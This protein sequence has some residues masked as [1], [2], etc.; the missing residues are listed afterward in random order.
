[1][2]HELHES[3][4]T[5][6]RDMF[7]RNI[8]SW[9]SLEVDSQILPYQLSTPD[10]ERIFFAKSGFIC[11]LSEFLANF[12]EGCEDCQGD[13]SNFQIFLKQS[14]SFCNKSSVETGL[15]LLKVT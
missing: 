1:M 14:V 15:D 3:L 10:F 6:R 12:S 8:N 4:I 13:R 9:N 11:K 5:T 2:I 7:A